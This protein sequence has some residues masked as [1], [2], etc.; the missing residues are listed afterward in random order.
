[1]YKQKVFLDRSVSQKYDTTGIAAGY[2]CLAVVSY[3][4]ALYSY[5]LQLYK[6]WAKFEQSCL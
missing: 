4:K 5:V 2:D 3:E 6:T 1:M